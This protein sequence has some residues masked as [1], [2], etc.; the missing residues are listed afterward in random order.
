M[1]GRQMRRAAVSL[2]ANIAE[3]YGRHHRR[4][5]V[6]YRRQSR[7]ALM[8]LIDA[9]NACCDLGYVTEPEYEQ[10]RSAARE[11]LQL[12]NG[13]IAYLPGQR[14]DRGQATRHSWREVS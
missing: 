3:G 6:Q 9:L 5:S 7:G 4:E 8:E 10:A 11:V 14:G 12:L 1:L 13:H 2:A